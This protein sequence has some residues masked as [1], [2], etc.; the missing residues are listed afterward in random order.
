MGKVK[1]AFKLSMWFDRLLNRLIGGHISI[2]NLTIY[3]RNAM[4]FA[5]NYRVKRG[6]YYICLCPPVYCWGRWWP[7]YLYLSRNGTPQRAHFIAG[8]NAPGMDEDKR[9]AKRRGQLLNALANA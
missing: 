1:L 6:R 3:G 9:R 7:W 5:W 2:G 8:Y 4:H